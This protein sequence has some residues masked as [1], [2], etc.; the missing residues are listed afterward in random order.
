MKKKTDEN[1][2]QSKA[3]VDNNDA[4][5]GAGGLPTPFSQVRELFEQDIT[6][7]SSR[8]L[9]TTVIADLRTTER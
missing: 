8:D 7:L 2:K 6:P 3:H 1:V 4:S 5:H 9:M